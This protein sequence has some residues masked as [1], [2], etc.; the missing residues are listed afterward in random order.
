MDIKLTSTYTELSIRLN[1]PMDRFQYIASYVA[2]MIND[3]QGN[4]ADIIK[5]VILNL[6]GNERYLVMYMMGRS[7]SKIF[8]K[9]SD[10]RQEEFV[11][12]ILGA[13][14]IT[15]ERIDPITTYILN[16]L[17]R[18][19]DK[20]DLPTIDIIRQIINSNFADNEKDYIMFTFGLIDII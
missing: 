18:E 2:Q 16:N 5:E 10:Q 12:S 4:V 14:K 8:S 13:L 15:E 19:E 17:I 20:T 9:A 3:Y 6:K 1:I 11:N 7:S